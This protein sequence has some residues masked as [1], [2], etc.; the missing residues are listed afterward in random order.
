V[1]ALTDVTGFGLAGHA[2]EIARGGAARCASTGPGAAAGRRARLAG[3]G[4]VTGAS[5]RNWAGYGADVTLPGGF[6]PQDQRPADRPADQRR[7]AGVVRAG[8]AG[9]GAGDLPAADRAAAFAQALPMLV[10]MALVV[11]VLRPLALLSDSLVRNNAVV[12]GVT[13]LIRWQSHWHV[14]RQSWPFFQN[15]F[16]G[17]IANRVMQTSNALRESVVSASAASGTSWSTAAR[18]WC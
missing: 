18:R 14:V 7:P 17:R 11:L 10:A 8:G 4:L 1:H 15:D 12:P 3:Q 13:S 16:A 6:A 5:G 2:L 9:R